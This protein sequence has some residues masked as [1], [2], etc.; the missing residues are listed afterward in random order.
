MIVGSACPNPPDSTKF[1][2]VKATKPLTLRGI[3]FTP[4]VLPSQINETVTMRCGG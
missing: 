3:P 1:V 2:T 4:T